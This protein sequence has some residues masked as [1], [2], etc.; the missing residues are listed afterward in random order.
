MPECY[1]SVVNGFETARP[2]FG[3][4]AQLQLRQKDWYG[5]SR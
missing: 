1:V 4:E 2:I 5:P 3:R